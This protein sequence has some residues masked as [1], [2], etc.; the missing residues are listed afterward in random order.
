MKSA[1]INEGPEKTYVLI[2]ET[3][4]EVM[5]GLKRFATEN[6]I[7]AARLTAIGAFESGILG[8]WETDRRQYR[9]NPFHEQVEVLAF[10]GDVARKDRDPVV[11]V[12]AV[13]GRP[14]ASTLGGHLLEARVRPTLEVVLVP[15]PAYLRRVMDP[16]AGLPLIEPEV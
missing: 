3:G 7:T 4:D 5:G 1:C 10:I 13:L 16:E 11:H 12:H 14:D 8:Y 2:F 9:R 6:G 15:S